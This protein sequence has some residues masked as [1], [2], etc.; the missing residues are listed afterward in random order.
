MNDTPNPDETP[1]DPPEPVKPRAPKRGA[2]PT[3][4]SD[5]E[6]A[7]PYIPDLGEEEDRPAGKPDRPTDTEGEKES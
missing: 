5:L 2:F 1:G 4:K 7:Q 6:K 3:S